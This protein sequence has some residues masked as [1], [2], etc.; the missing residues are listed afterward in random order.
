MNYKQYLAVPS[1]IFSLSCIQPT[2]EPIDPD[3]GRFLQ[4][5]DA[6]YLAQGNRNTLLTKQRND[7]LQHVD[8]V[9][10]YDEA[11]QEIIS[12]QIE[13]DQ[14]WNKPMQRL[15]DQ[16]F[17]AGWIFPELEETVRKECEKRKN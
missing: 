8:Q 15:V 1:L 9:F 6:T 16:S 12:C 11:G 3:Q 5:V 13:L 7:P 17:T 14:D 4:T 2:Q 10:Y